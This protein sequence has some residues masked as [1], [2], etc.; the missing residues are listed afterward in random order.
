[1][2]E[3]RCVCL[4]GYKELKPCFCSS[5]G[6]QLRIHGRFAEGAY[7]LIF[8]VNSLPLFLPE[9]LMLGERFQNDAVCLQGRVSERD[10]GLETA[11]SLLITTSLCSLK[12][13]LR[14]ESKG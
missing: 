3:V 10:F 4:E 6:A 5:K 9:R 1:M 12:Y 11:L 8:Q 14:A 13:G 2:F 7:L